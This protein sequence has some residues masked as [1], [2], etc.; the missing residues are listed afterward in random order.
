MPR[1]QLLGEQLKMP[2][3]LVAAMTNLRDRDS[4]ASDHQ[5]EIDDIAPAQDLLDEQ[6]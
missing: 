6:P 5:R 4:I 3:R 2:K 1:E